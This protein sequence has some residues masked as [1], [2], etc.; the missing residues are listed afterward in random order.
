MRVVNTRAGWRA[1][2]WM[3]AV[4]GLLAVAFLLG[5]ETATP[6][7]S[8]RPDPAEAAPSAVDVGFCQD[9]AA[10][11]EQA[12]LMSSLADGRAGPAVKAL[13]DS[14]LMGQSEELGAM[15]GWLQLWGKP[16]VSSSP[17]L[18]MSGEASM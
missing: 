15:R 8:N 11:H 4:I 16:A 12:V 18:W 9:M 1:S 3:S 17:M 13:A 2:V 5:Q 6:A 10:H 14:I 7:V